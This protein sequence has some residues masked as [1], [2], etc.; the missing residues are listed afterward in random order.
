L[1]KTL[2]ERAGLMKAALHPLYSRPNL[3]YTSTVFPTNRFARCAMKFVRWA[4]IVLLG[5]LSISA[6]FGS[7]PMIAD[8][9]GAPTGMPQSLLQYSPFP[10]FLV[11]GLTLLIA[12]GLLALW[13]MWLALAQ[14]HRFGQWTVLQGF[15]LLAW[16]VIE[17]ILLRMVIWPHYLYGAVAVGLIAAGALLWRGESRPA[18]FGGNI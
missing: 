10:S 7:I 15:V 4:A 1:I 9:H 14:I 6:I 8:P 11:P 17:C 18:S 16:L 5:F 12:N 2:L 3:D 13:V